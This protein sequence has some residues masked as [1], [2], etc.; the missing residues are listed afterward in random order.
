MSQTENQ[1]KRRKVDFGTPSFKGFTTYRS[2]MLPFHLVSVRG[3]STQYAK[4]RDTLKASHYIGVLTTC[5]LP[6]YLIKSLDSGFCLYESADSI[7]E[8]FLQ[9]TYAGDNSKQSTVIYG[10]SSVSNMKEFVADHPIRTYFETEVR[11]LV[12]SN[13]VSLLKLQ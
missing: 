8:F 13:D 5:H 1:N 11:P 3:R 9:F 7:Y 6:L 12:E 10:K 2:V 4:L